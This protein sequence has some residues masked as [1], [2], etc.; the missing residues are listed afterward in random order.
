MIPGLFH[1]LK[2]INGFLKPFGLSVGADSDASAAPSEDSVGSYEAGSV[3]TKEI[4][5][6]VFPDRIRTGLEENGSTGGYASE[7]ALTL[8]HEVGHALMEQLIDYSENIPEFYP[9]MTAK[10]GSRFF[11]IFNDDNLSEEDI[12]EAFAQRFHSGKNSILQSCWEESNKI[13][14]NL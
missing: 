7:L 2:K 1:P 13:L 5:V 11:D 3:F 14:K 6:H 12:V 9:S 4:L 8:Y 10:F